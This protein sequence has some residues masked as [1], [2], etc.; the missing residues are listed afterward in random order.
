MSASIATVPALIGAV[1]ARLWR[2]EGWAMARRAAWVSAGAMLLVAVVHLSAM[3]VTLVAALVPIGLLWLA[4]LARAAWRRPTDAASALW[5]DRHLG[6]ASAFTTWLE[7]SSGADRAAHPQAVEWLERW[8]AARVPEASRL[9]AAQRTPTHIAPALLSMAV[10][11]VLALVV[12]ALPA[13][14]PT[15][16][17]QAAAP[18]QIGRAE[19]AAPIVEG[20]AATQLASDLSSALRSAGS[21]YEEVEQQSRG[22]AP[23]S[24][25]V[26]PDERDGPPQAPSNAGPAGDAATAQA[27]RSP[28]SASPADVSAGASRTVASERISGR[29][30]GESPDARADVGVSRAAGGTMIVK[31]SATRE[32]LTHERQADMANAA[33]F[34]DGLNDTGNA[35]SRDALVAAAATP[36]PA[37][38]EARLSP[39][40]SRYVQA[41]MKASGRSL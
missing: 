35:P 37:I 7:A 15:S 36:P 1:R 20:P 18:A 6:G 26:E 2:D 5:I 4:M 14:V 29:A 13:V 21:R 11:T 19:P 12:L 30:A 27:R 24:G 22:R 25:T 32:T 31:R 17:G 23:A 9:L 28:Q 3:S 16:R 40:E 39:A 34:D 38:D 10:C 8:T 41:W 33:T